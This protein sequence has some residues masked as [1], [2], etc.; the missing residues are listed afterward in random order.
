M[1]VEGQKAC[2][3]LFLLCE[4]KWII[5]VFFRPYHELVNEEN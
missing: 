2:R 5:I 3:D 4:G 1:A